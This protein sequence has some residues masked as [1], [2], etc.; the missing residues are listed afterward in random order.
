PRRRRRWR[1]P[2]GGAPNWLPFVMCGLF[3]LLRFVFPNGGAGRRR[4]GMVGGVPIGGYGGRRGGFGG[5]GFRGGG[6]S[7][8]GG[9]ASGGW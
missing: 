4:R 7:F 2:Q 3:M 8:G 9:G 6:G 5:G 1:D